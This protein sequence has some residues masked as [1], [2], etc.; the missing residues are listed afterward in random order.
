MNIQTLIRP[1]EN[2]ENI[3]ESILIN[4]NSFPFTRVGSS[5]HC[6]TR[7]PLSAR[8]CA[9]KREDNPRKTIRLRVKMNIIIIYIR[10]FISVNFY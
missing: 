6:R 7:S 8:L 4:C 9:V 1:N 3:P 2:G 5:C 10:I